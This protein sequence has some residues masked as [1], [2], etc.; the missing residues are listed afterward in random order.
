MV[1]LY[2][3]L[4][5]SNQTV[6]LP[7][8]TVQAGVKH[9]R[10]L[11]RSIRSRQKISA[12]H[13]TCNSNSRYLW[14]KTLFDMHKLFFRL[15]ALILLSFTNSFACAQTDSAW[16]T[17]YEPF[18]IAGNL[19]YVGTYDLACYL[20]TTSQGHILI[21]TGLAESVPMI[22]KNIE[23]LGFNYNDLSVL[24]TTQAHFDHVAGM[25]EIK[26]NTG[27]K[28]MVHESDAAVL[29][30]GGKSDFLF[31]GNSNFA[32]APVSVDRILHDRD[33]I[34]L[35]ETTVTILHHPGHTKGASSFLLDVKDEKR[36]WRV[37]IV[38]I[39]SILSQTRI[40]GMPAYPN[41]GK[42]YARTLAS[43]RELK[44]DL[45]VASHA[46]QFRLHDKRKPG[47][48]YRPEAF[49]D[50]PGYEASL[51]TIKKEYD[52]RLTKERGK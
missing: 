20:I 18:R 26:K 12:L 22:R 8:I 42:D 4:V 43:L 35:G 17:P 3:K 51:N 39:P 47:D 45:W 44:F 1:P 46:G 25:A 13:S 5:I 11:P 34:T 7:Y 9:A 52:T 27:A 50:R 28:M 32:F 16:V 38:N 40:S 6:S 29:A 10:M 33:I 37:L 48:P 19:Y 2:Q 15:P 24:L 21:N 41:V 30:D 14:S 49:D 36:S 31:G 23:V